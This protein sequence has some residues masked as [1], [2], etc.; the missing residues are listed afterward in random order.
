MIAGVNAARRVRE[1]PPIVLRRDQAY[2]GVLIDDLVTKGTTEPY[3]MFTSR[4][5]YRL[6][7][8]QDN[9][10]FRLS[11]IGY[12]CGLLP[13]REYQTFLRKQTLIN[14]EMER[15][16]VTRDGTASLAELLRRPE[17]SYADLP[18]T[19]PDLPTD[20]VEQVEIEL[21]YAGY[22][23]RQD[24]DI[25]KFKAMEEKQIPSWLDYS[26]IPSLRTEARQKLIKIRPATVGQAS[27]ISGV[28]PADLSLVLV[29]MKRGPLEPEPNAP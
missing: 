11:P 13:N 10:D 1:K 22:I 8:R 28:S 20:V 15:L 7:L 9:A 17:L 29:W 23:A 3:R 24:V 16:S 27:R 12:E 2:I 4:A 14:A 26:T 6:T 5:E 19:K 18:G 25:A 21:K